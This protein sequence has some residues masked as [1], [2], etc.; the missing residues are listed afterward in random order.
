MDAMAPVVKELQRLNDG[1]ALKNVCIA[2]AR[3]EPPPLAF[4]L[5]F[6]SLLVITR[7]Q[8]S[9]EHS[10]AGKIESST[11]G[12][13]DAL[14]A[15][16]NCWYRPTWHSS[17][18]TVTFLFGK[19]QI[20]LSLVRAQVK[21][22]GEPAYSRV[23][24]H[25]TNY[26]LNG[27]LQRILQACEDLGGEP[28]HIFPLRHFLKGL[29]HSCLQIAQTPLINSHGKGQYL[30]QTICSYVQSHFH[31]PLSRENVAEIFGVTPNHI[32]RVF[33]REGLMRFWDYVVMVR[34]D[35][36]KF[37][38]R[39]YDFPVKEVSTRCGYDDCDYFCRLFRR[40]VR[41]TPLEYRYKYKEST[42][43]GSP[44]ATV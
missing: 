3:A 11:L 18:T 13:G 9:F 21:R 44:L 34:V 2:E 42:P 20:G 43:A 16:A 22:P 5:G 35:R 15:P 37:L 1:A 7:G 27:P 4:V 33:Q 39:T 25:H 26:P 8:Y 14:L 17:N 19:R 29:I 31:E 12:Q 36:A 23:L 41:M 28:S 30:F 40:K 38:L 32:S 24:K 10:R 6:P